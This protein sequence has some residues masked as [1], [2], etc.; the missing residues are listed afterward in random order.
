MTALET[1]HG[2]DALHP[3]L[4]ETVLGEPHRIGSNFSAAHFSEEAFDGRMDP[5]L[6][7]DHFV[8]TGPTFEPHLHAGISAVTVMFEDATGHFLNRDTLGRDVA[9]EPGDL[10]WLAAASG[11]A[12]EERPA[13]GARVHA[14]RVFVNLPARLKAQPARAL[15]VRAA[16]I[17]SLLGHLTALVSR[18]ARTAGCTETRDAA[19][20]TYSAVTGE[21]WS[22]WRGGTKTLASTAA[23]LDAREALRTK[24]AGDYARTHPGDQVVAFRASPQ[25]DTSEDANRI[26]DALNWALAQWPQMKLATT[27]AKGAEKI[28]IKWARQKSVD[29]ILARVD[30]NRHGKA[31]GDQGSRD[32]HSLPSNAAQGTTLDLCGARQTV[33]LPWSPC[34][35]GHLGS[36]WPW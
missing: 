5:L 11:A 1:I 6:M 12:H 10:Y 23:H 4:G 24:R 35:G 36:R 26:F 17:P 2:A 30:F 29:V 22:P 31:A 15:H 16:D 34:R 21:V 8:M 28:A 9:L 18:S 20:D 27:G 7:V 3:R 14:L 19:C 32:R 13:E 33:A 25:A